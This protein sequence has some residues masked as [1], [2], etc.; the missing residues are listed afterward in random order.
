MSVKVN[1]CMCM[2]FLCRKFVVLGL[3]L[4][5]LSRFVRWNRL[6]S[7]CRFP[8]LRGQIVYVSVVMWC[9]IGCLRLIDE[10]YLIVM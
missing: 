10:G 3:L 1:V 4:A 9:L 5:V 8:Y 7:W 6:S 2:C